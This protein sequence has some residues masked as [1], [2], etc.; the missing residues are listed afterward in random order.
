MVHIKIKVF[1]IIF[2]WYPYWAVILV[3]LNTKINFND[4]FFQSNIDILLVNAFLPSTQGECSLYFVL[5]CNIF[6][7]TK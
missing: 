6:C 2:Y 5:V 3:I 1:I 4:F 7:R